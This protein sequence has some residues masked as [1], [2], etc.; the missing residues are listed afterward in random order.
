MRPCELLIWDPIDCKKT[1]LGGT[2]LVYDYALTL[3][4]LMQCSRWEGPCRCKIAPGP[5]GT[6]IKANEAS[7]LNSKL[8]TNR[9]R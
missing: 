3:I 6:T 5:K 4:T 1:L 8:V 7:I 9:K 2:L